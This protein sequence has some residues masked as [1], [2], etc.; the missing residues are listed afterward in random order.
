L[1]KH[2][3]P[4]RKS[5]FVEKACFVL[6]KRLEVPFVALQKL[7]LYSRCVVEIPCLAQV[8]PPFSF[9]TLPNPEVMKTCSVQEHSPRIKQ[10]AENG[11]ISC[12][13]AA[14]KKQ[15]VPHL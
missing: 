5:L 13:F 11:S 12:P 4:H 7:V 8:A 15:N 10:R 1:K 14:L 9:G 6:L 2:I 3:F